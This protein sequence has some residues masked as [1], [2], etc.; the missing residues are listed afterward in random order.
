MTLPLSRSIVYGYSQS[1]S[2]TGDTNDLALTPNV[3]TVTVTSSTG[4]H[5][6][7]GFTGGTPGRTFTLVNTTSSTIPIPNQ[8]GSSSANQ[9]TTGTGSSYLLH[10]GTQV[11]FTY[12]GGT[13]KWVIDRPSPPPPHTPSLSTDQDDYPLLSTVF[14]PVLGADV[15][16]TGFDASLMPV[17]VPYTLVNPYGSGFD[18][19]LSHDDPASSAD[20]QLQLSTGADV[21]VG[22]GESVVLVNTGS[23][24]ADAGGSLSLAPGGSS[25]AGTLLG[26][27]TG[28]NAAAI[29]CAGLGGYRILKLYGYGFQTKNALIT[30]LLMRTSSDN[31]SSYASGGSDY[32]SGGGAAAQ[33]TIS[34]ALPPDSTASSSLS[35]EVTV[36]EADVSG[37]SRYKIAQWSTSAYNSGLTNSTGSGARLSDAVINAV[38]FLGTTSNLN[39]TVKAY[40]Y[41]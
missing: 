38:R 18:F 34:I 24:I 41:N 40:G 25:G 14:V 35:F 7:T 20:N 2:L 28:A 22:P 29:D 32:N 9:V 39:G 12:D 4:G 5:D 36:Y 23:G 27:F 21:V 19:T 16:F 15:T 13:S 3:T 30:N 37:A 6:M 1:V 17:G 31:G 11:T 8:S 26:T 33:I 10:P